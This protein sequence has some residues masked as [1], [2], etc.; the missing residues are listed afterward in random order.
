MSEVKLQID[1]REVRVPEGTSI[2]DAAKAIGVEVPQLC[3]REDL[4]PSSA[5]RLCV[6]GVEG[7]RTL[8][9]SC[10]TIAVD[11][12]A[13][14]TDNERTARARKLV[15][16][17]LLSDHDPECPHD[18]ADAACELGRWARE[19]NVD[20]SRYE[21]E[22]RTYD[23]DDST[24]FFVLDHSRCILCERCITACNEV[25]HLGAIGLANRGF[26][27]KVA[28]PFDLP[29]LESACTSCGQCLSVCPTGAI[30]LKSPIEQPIRTVDTTCPYC[31]VGCGI[32]ARVDSEDRIVEVL[33]DPENQSSLGRLCVKG[34]FG[35]GFV[36]HE[37]RLTQ[38][39][40]RR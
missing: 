38:P 31:G 30:R 1:G 18:G 35:F 25:Q 8:A 19:F 33:E 4:P 5:C 27:A 11:N 16:E 39:L 34:R 26:A 24:P 7:A 28:T 29:L 17:L 21:G 14:E 15:I 9:A 13:V 10:S 22:R 37:D 12:M 2:L 23:T 3:H 32:K 40:I 6:V 36:N 20:G